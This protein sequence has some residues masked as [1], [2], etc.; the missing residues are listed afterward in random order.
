VRRRKLELGLVDEIIPEPL[1][2]AH[3]DPGAM[4]KTLQRHLLKQL[5]KLLKLSVAD[6]LKQR[7][8]KFRAYG[9][10]VEKKAGTP[11]LVPN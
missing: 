11:E 6:R 2:G 3:T 7:Y 1:G 9:H 8:D 5:G 10:F 4:A